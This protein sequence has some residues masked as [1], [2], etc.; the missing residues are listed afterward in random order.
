MKK[1]NK[2]LKIRNEI[3]SLALFGYRNDVC[4]HINIRMG[5]WIDGENILAKK[6]LTHCVKQAL[7][8]YRLPGY[9]EGYDSTNIFNNSQKIKKLFS[10]FTKE[11]LEK[12]YEEIKRIYNY[13]QMSLKG[14]DKNK[15]KT[16]KLRRFLSIF[17]ISQV[18][19]QILK[20][21]PFI[22]YRTNIITSY[23]TDENSYGYSSP[24][25]L[26]RE[27]KFEDVLLHNRYVQ[28]S[29]YSCDY[30]DPE[31][32]VWVLNRNIFGEVEYSLNKF[33]WDEKKLDNIVEHNYRNNR[34]FSE[35]DNYTNYKIERPCDNK[36]IKIFIN[37][38][39]KWKN[40]K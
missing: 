6:L 37:L 34:Y 22:K 30:I 38:E 18:I 29:G 23:S 20:K 21:K 13:T 25:Y 8:I 15:N 12:A 35:E 32:E 19:D 5:G 1:R 31:K 39:Q 10:K 28:Y 40:I 3:V 14:D 2:K 24:I 16:I 17:E 7:N 33:K 36:L 27:V 11:E 9:E 4:K 26:E